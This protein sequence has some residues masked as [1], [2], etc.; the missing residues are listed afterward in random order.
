MENLSF[1]ELA[2]QANKEEKE[3]KKVLKKKREE[4]KKEEKEES[5]IKKETLKLSSPEKDFGI[6]FYRGMWEGITGK[7]ERDMDKAHLKV[8][9]RKRLQN[10]QEFGAFLERIVHFLNLQGGNR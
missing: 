3:H 7:V 10:P 5:P 2:I 8:Q 6:S 1:R 9:I 4:R